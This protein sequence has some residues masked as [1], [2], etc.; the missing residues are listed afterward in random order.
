MRANPY[1]ESATAL[2][3]M[4]TKPITLP[5]SLVRA[6]NKGCCSEV[7][8]YDHEYNYICIKYNSRKVIIVYFLSYSAMIH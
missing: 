8:F 1:I 7:F 6:G 5:C 4:E 2:S 3:D